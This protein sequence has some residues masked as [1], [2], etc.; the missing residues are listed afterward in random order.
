MSHF[1][2]PREETLRED[3]AIA[4]SERMHTSRRAVRVHFSPTP[5]RTPEKDGPFR[6]LPTGEDA[7]GYEYTIVKIVGG[8]LEANAKDCGYHWFGFEHPR[9]AGQ[10]Q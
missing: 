4:V 7:R 10:K 8:I 3:I 9:L 1:T 2:C 6:I 5:I